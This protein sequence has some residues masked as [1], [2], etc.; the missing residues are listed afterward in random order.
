MP[1]VGGTAYSQA[2]DALAFARA[3]IDDAYSASG[4]ILTGTVPG[5]AAPMSYQYL[6]AAYQYLQEELTNNGVETFVK[7]VVLT[8]LTATPSTDPSTQVSLSDDG[9]FDGVNA[10]WP[11]PQLPIDMVNTGP[12]RVWE[13]MSSNPTTVF[14][15][16][17][18][19]FDG[20]PGYSLNARFFC[21]EWRQDQ[22]YMPGAIQS[23]DLRIR[24]NQYLANLNADTD[25]VLIRRSTNALGYLTAWNYAITSGDPMVA[26][27]IMSAANQCIQQMV[28]RSSR[29]NQH[30]G[31]IRRRGYGSPRGGRGAWSARW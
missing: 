28:V 3:V 15:P 25:F 12:L 26:E 21:W 7:E 2:K 14:L 9:Y 6:N 18:R 24:Y 11:N 16:M 31:P 30:G 13:R 20:L 23:N 4:Q 29:A 19:S 8:G 17:K 1:I 10:V 27:T 5:P 22:M